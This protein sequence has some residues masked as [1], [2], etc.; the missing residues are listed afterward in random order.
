M[1]VGDCNIEDK[2][3]GREGGGSWLGDDGEEIGGGLRGRGLPGTPLRR[4]HEDQ[5]F[6]IGDGWM[7]ERLFP[8]E[9]QH[10]RAPAHERR[11]RSFPVL[12]G[13]VR[14]GGQ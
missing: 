8:W 10:P 5:G 9:A 13:L 2:V 4:G 7:R 14:M 6:R 1:P 12:S 3:E 11:H